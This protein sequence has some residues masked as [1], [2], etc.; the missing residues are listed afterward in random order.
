[1]KCCLL[2]QRHSTLFYNAIFVFQPPRSTKTTYNPVRSAKRCFLRKLAQS[3]A[4]LHLSK[5]AASALIIKV[6]KHKYDCIQILA[7][8]NRVVLQNYDVQ[9]TRL[10]GSP[11]HV[12]AQRGSTFCIIKR[13]YI[14]ISTKFTEIYPDIDFN[15]QLVHYIR[16][17][18]VSSKIIEYYLC[19]VTDVF[20]EVAILHYQPVLVMFGRVIADGESEN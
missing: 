18:T 16:F 7:A 10:F 5:H 15:R 13:F 8:V 1:M 17:L 19:R 6:R 20:N 12:T 9:Y 4:N 2:S 11:H 3:Y 14:L